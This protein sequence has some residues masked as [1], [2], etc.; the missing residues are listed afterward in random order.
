MAFSG[1]SRSLFTEVSG[2][3]DA[4]YLR[5]PLRARS[6]PA[7]AGAAA[8]L[9]ALALLWGCGSST[10]PSD[11]R[12][13]NYAFTWQAAPGTFIELPARTSGGTVS[14]NLAGPSHLFLWFQVPAYDPSVVVA[15]WTGVDWQ[16]R[17]T[18]TGTDPVSGGPYT[19][20]LVLNWTPGAS[21]K[22]VLTTNAVQGWPGS[23]T[24][25]YL[26]T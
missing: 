13:G 3:P 6:A 10:E 25:T 17:I 12:A 5:T 14:V 21:C 23:C 20:F 24:F 11:T 2:S 9:F 8:R 19:Y 26:G 4:A 22:G 15:D 18:I 7:S 16:V 1:D